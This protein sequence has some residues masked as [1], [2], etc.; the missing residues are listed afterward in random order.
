VTR[1]TEPA[2]RPTPRRS[3]REHQRERTRAAL[4]DATRAVIRS[5][6]EV[7]MPAIA[8]AAGVSEPTAY[9]YFPDLLSIMRE[10]FVG[11]WPSADELMP[12]LQSCPDPVERIGIAA[13][14]LGDNMFRIEGAVRTMIA[15]TI[16]R[17]DA[18]GARPGHR[19]ALIESALAPLSARNE[20]ADRDRLSQLRNDLAVVVS[21]EALFT[22][23]DLKSMAPE[24]AVASVSTAARRLVTEAVRDLAQ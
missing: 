5:G 3:Q 6:G 13:N 18:I 22:L 23:V 10:G 12:S 16:N 2:V 8:R 17:R 7:T 24:A 11:V 15:L 4:V 9:R 21:A 14:M 1:R 20:A 19:I